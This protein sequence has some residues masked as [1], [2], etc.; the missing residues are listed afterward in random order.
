MRAVLIVFYWLFFSGPILAE[1]Q[2]GLPEN[3]TSCDVLALLDM[4]RPEGCTTSAMPEPGVV[5]RIDDQMR[6]ARPATPKQEAPVKTTVQ[7][8][9]APEDFVI[10]FANGS[11]VLS[12]QSK[13]QLGRLVRLGE[14]VALSDMC[15]RITGHSDARGEAA[16]NKALSKQRVLNVARY[17]V[18]NGTFSPDRILLKAAGEEQ[19]IK[20]ISINDPRQRR[21]TLELNGR[22]SQC[23]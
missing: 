4:P 5:V 21:V 2:I 12:A 17:L 7:R 19:P 15:L 10:R 20:N 1:G 6:A 13:T 9:F 23:G 8:S 16:L 22:N 3:E 14:T 11:A 18:K